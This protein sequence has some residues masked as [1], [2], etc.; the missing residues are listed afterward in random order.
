MIYHSYQKEWKVINVKNS[1]DGPDDGPHDVDDNA[2]MPDLETKEEAAD[3]YE[4]KKEIKTSNND[5]IKKLKDRI[6]YL[7]TKFRDNK[8]SIEEKDKLHEE[9]QN[10]RAEIYDMLNKFQDEMEKYYNKLSKTDD[11]LDKSNDRLNKLN[12]KIIKIKK[13]L[14]DKTLS[15]DER[16][17]LQNEI[18][19]LNRELKEEKKIK[20]LFIIKILQQ[21]DNYE[22]L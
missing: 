11:I 16:N 5:K 17:K 15:D 2:D 8:L 21:Q 7:E 10:N 20:K 18:K 1:D 19:D 22:N 6:L 14:N 12:D 4:Q 9:L 13:V 3:F